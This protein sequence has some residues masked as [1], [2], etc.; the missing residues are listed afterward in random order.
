MDIT[1]K[2]IFSLLGLLLAAIIIVGGL[3]FFKP[4]LFV[5]LLNPEMS[6]R[7]HR[8][9]A[10]NEQTATFNVEIDLKNKTFVPINATITGLTVKM[11]GEKLADSN[12]PLQFKIKPYS[13]NNLNLPIE[14]QMSL[15]KENSANFDPN[16]ID[17]AQYDISFT[18]V[19]KTLFGIRDSSTVT[20]TFKYPK[21]GLPKVE[22]AS[23]EILKSNFNIQRLEIQAEII[24]PNPNDIKIAS[25]RYSIQIDDR[26]D[27]IT[28]NLG[29]ELVLKKFSSTQKTIIVEIENNKILKFLGE[30]IGNGKNLPIKLLFMGELINDSEIMKEATIKLEVNG[31]L[32]ALIESSKQRSGSRQNSD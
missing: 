20:E 28:G 7:I 9:S 19:A 2:I 14:V 31:D 3:A 32:K 24:N 6:A 26:E 17:S 22:I 27:F 30:L 16:R 11:D 23:V 10:M 29:K 4:S 5:E 21:L 15:L 12:E 8:V 1:K 25:P 18:Y 13:Q